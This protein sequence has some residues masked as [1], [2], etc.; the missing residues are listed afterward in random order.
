MSPRLVACRRKSLPGS[1]TFRG[2]ALS[3]KASAASPSSAPPSYPVFRE[4]RDDNGAVL[5]CQAGFPFAAVGESLS[6][7][8]PTGRHAAPRLATPSPPRS[9]RT[10][11]CQFDFP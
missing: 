4:W 2:S 3:P 11:V 1:P 6:L 10:S 7:R 8:K 9:S 5:G